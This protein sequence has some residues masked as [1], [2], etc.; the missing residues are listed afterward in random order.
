MKAGTITLIVL[1]VGIAAVAAFAYTTEY[2]DKKDEVALQAPISK[3]LKVQLDDYRIEPPKDANLLKQLGAAQGQASAK[4]DDHVVVLSRGLDSNTKSI[5]KMLEG[6]NTVNEALSNHAEQL[7]K[8][9]TAVKNLESR[10]G[11][12]EDWKAGFEEGYKA[13]RKEVQDLKDKVSLFEKALGKIALV[14]LTTPAAAATRP[15]VTTTGNVTEPP[16]GSVIEPRRVQTE[17]YPRP[18]MAQATAPR[19]EE[20]L[21]DDSTRSLKGVP[22]AE[23]VSAVKGMFKDRCDEQVAD[24]TVAALAH[25][26]ASDPKRKTVQSLVDGVTDYCSARATLR[27]ERE[28]FPRPAPPKGTTLS[29]VSEDELMKHTMSKSDACQNPKN[30]W[31][32]RE[33][34]HNGRRMMAVFKCD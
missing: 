27:E 14:S 12:I 25:K 26:L 11:T 30:G 5:G 4:T 16:Q 29:K 18:Q 17:A 31:G 24:S 7:I 15:P 32:Y 1:G 2:G 10:I 28:K 21:V 3:D 23:R 8:Q 13:N 33:V 20:Q 34:E 22:H 19:Q 9:G 6:L